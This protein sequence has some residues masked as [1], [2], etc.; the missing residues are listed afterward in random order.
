MADKIEKKLMK[1]LM[2]GYD[3]RVRPSTNTTHST[4]VTFGLALAQLI[5]VVRVT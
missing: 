2:E 3:K 5:D 4:P 1:D